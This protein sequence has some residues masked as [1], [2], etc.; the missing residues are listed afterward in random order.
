MISG[1]MAAA[2]YPGTFDPLTYGHLDVLR[3]GAAL[4]DRVIVAV[5]ARIDKRT[6]LEPE[7]RVELIREA[8]S[9]MSNVEVEAFD[10]LV[11]DFAHR[12]GAQVLLRGIRNPI[13]YGY[14]AQMA[15]TNMRLRPELETVFLVASGDV[16]FISSTLVREILEAGGAI[17]EFVPPNVAA[18]LRA[19]KA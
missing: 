3:R 8:V 16:A 2:L 18:A 1:A 13:D 10:G 12:C 11:A 9:S 7:R 6:L 5:G 4:F 14:E 15:T 17:E 19:L